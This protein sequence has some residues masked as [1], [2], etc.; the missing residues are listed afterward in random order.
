MLCAG[1]LATEAV[2]EYLAVCQLFGADADDPGNGDHRSRVFS[3]HDASGG[4]NADLL[5]SVRHRDPV[6]PDTGDPIFLS[7]CI[8]T[9][10][11]TGDRI[12]LL[13]TS[14]ADR[15]RSG[16]TDDCQGYQACKRDQ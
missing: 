6:L 11:Q 8:V 10:K 7:V 2:P 15:C 4:T 13:Q 9:E 12:Y 5:F 14:H 16:R 3:D 1:I